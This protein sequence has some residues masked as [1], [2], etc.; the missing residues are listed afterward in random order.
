M[1]LV[2]ANLGVVV[3]ETAVASDTEKNSGGVD[4]V[5]AATSTAAAAAAAGERGNTGG[6]R[7]GWGTAE[8]TEMIMNNLFYI[9][10]KVRFGI[11]DVD[12][13]C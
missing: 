9:T 12:N 2:D 4:K 7:E 13:T 11:E 5:G 8:A 10:V 1:E 6:G 3:A